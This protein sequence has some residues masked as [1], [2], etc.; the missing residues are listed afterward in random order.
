MRELTLLISLI[1]LNF[2]TTNAYH[3]ALHIL[4]TAL[5]ILFTALHILLTAA[6]TEASHARRTNA[7]KISHLSAFFVLAIATTHINASAAHDQ[8]KKAKQ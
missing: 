6:G 8:K 3:I 7:R 4:L 1:L 2:R 5:N